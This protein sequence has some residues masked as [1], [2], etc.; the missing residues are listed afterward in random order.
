MTARVLIDMRVV[1]APQP[2]GLA[3]AALAAGRALTGRGRFD[4]LTIGG[5]VSHGRRLPIEIPVGDDGRAARWLSAM[6]SLYEADLFFSTYYPL[7]PAACP[8]V[9]TIHDL[10][11]LRRPE[12]FADARVVSFFDIDVRASARRASRIVVDT[13]CVRQDVVQ[14]LEVDPARVVV[15]PLAPVSRGGTDAEDEERLRRVGVNGPFV[16]SVATLEP[17]KNLVRLMKAFAQAH[18]A[19]SGRPV[20]LV[21][22]GRLGWKWDEILQATG[23]ADRVFAV[24][25]VDDDTLGSLYRRALALAYP[26]LAEG[27]GLPLL[28]AMAAGCPVVASDIP[29]FREVTGGH[30]HFVEPRDVESIAA[31]LVRVAGDAG[32]RGELAHRGLVH[33]R[34]YSWQRT[35]ESLEGVFREVLQAG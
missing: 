19:E 8:T 14:L 7:P 23:A 30:A 15:V 4:Y 18:P 20:S 2:A 24:G 17:R 21:L 1:E 6:A 25:Y 10:L 13:Q 29:V 27:F 9:L 5:S 12:W 31:G 16:L 22:A 35:A 28:E 26:S 32:L 11:P 33:A 34:Q 3:K